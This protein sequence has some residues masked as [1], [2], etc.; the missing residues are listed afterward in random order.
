M[1][2]FFSIILYIIAGLFLA[3]T[4]GLSY[5][6]PLNAGNILT[7]IIFLMF[8][9]SSIFFLLASLLYPHKNFYKPMCITWITSTIIITI[10][11]VNQYFMMKGFKNSD[12]NASIIEGLKKI[13]LPYNF[14]LGIAM[15]I[16][17]L[18]ISFYFYIESE[19]LS[20]IAME[21]DNN[22]K[23]SIQKKWL[24]FFGSF[25]IVFFLI[26]GF[27]K[28]FVSPEYSNLIIFIAEGE[29]YNDEKEYDQAIVSFQKALDIDPNNDEAHC[30]LGFSYICKKE[31]TKSIDY[32]NKYLKINPSS[33]NCYAYESLYELHI[34]QD[35]PLN[36]KDEEKYIAL[37]QEEKEYFIV[38]EM[39]NIMHSISKG[40][41]PDIVAWS[42]K[43]D[44]IDSEWD[45]EELH[46]WV[47][48]RK[49]DN[50]KQE[51]LKA[52]KV[53]ENHDNNL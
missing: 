8:A 35:L 18:L 39:L 51:L 47:N 33:D 13:G 42:R 15:S 34:I 10:G 31:Y 32:Y 1:R 44:G 38:Y 5:T 20:K 7:G 27:S 45:F 49:E 14:T 17:F 36:V 12:I 46:L 4:I 11:T 50:I 29:M 28:V 48:K 30:G 19:K 6:E 23:A 52:L 37:F 21:D 43:Y 26:Y 22:E 53:F 3:L 24:P 25:T 2:K 41:N 40:N 16:L 9:L